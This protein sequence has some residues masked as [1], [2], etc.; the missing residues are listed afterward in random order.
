MVNLQEINFTPILY[1]IYD[2][3]Y[4]NITVS[5]SQVIRADRF[6]FYK[7]SMP[8]R[9]RTIHYT[10]IMSTSPVIRADSF[11]FY[12]TSM[13]ERNRTIHYTAIMSASQVIRIESKKHRSPFGLRC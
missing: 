1:Q 13:P 6:I 9:N 3:S 2:N 4:I 10:A 7:T 8:E 5:T 12:K 11:I